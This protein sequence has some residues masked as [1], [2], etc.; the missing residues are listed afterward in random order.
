MTRAT[1]LIAGVSLL[2]L[3]SPAL[4]QQAPPPAAP[5]PTATLETVVVT[6]TKREENLQAVPVAVTALTAET[7]KTQRI[8]EFDDITRAVASLTLTED[9]ASPNNVIVLRGVGTFALSIG[10]EPSIAVI[11]DDVPVVQQAQAFDSLWDL[12]RIEVLEGPQGTLFGK[13][14]S[15][16]VINI[17]TKDPSSTPSASAQFTAT[18]DSDFKGEA[19]LSGPINDRVGFRISA[20]DD[21][22]DGNVRNLTDGHLLND[23]TNYGVRVKLKAEVTDKLTATFGASFGREDQQGAAYTLRYIDLDYVKPG[24]TTPVVP[25]VYGQSFLPDLVGI[26]PGPGNYKVYLDNDEP[27]TNQQVTVSGKLDY[28]FGF[29]DLLSITSY[30][31]WKYNFTADVDLSDRNT[32]GG[33]PAVTDPVGPADGVNNSGPY[34]STE[35]TQELRLVSK[36]PGPLSYV[37]GA[38]YADAPS[39]RYFQRGPTLVLADW[40]GYQDTRSFAGFASVDYKLPTKTTITG[41]FRVN[42]ERIQD[43]FVNYLPSATDY[44]SPTNVGTCGAGSAL[45]AGHN[46]DTAVTWKAAIDQELAP[47]V[48]AYFSAATGYKGYAYDIS[49]GYN[50]LRTEN[51]VLPEHST[52]FEVGIKSRFLDDRVQLNVTGFYADYNNFQAQ[53]AQY[54]DG[55]LQSK[56]N[57]VGKLRTRGF[58]GDLEA[59]A[60]EW[61][62][63][64]GSAAYTEA[65]I[66]SFPN[67]A[68]YAGQAADQL[69]EGI[70]AG[71]TG[72]GV[73]GYSTNPTGLGSVQDRSGAT[74]PNSPKLKFTMAAT[75]QHDLTTNIHGFGTLSYQHQSSVNFD[76]LGDPLL[77]Q[78][79]YGVFN[80]QAGASKGAFTVTLFANNLLNTHYASTMIDNFGTYG[81][82]SVFQQLPRDSQRYFGIK[83]S[84]SY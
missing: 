15:A 8:G 56:L 44:V 42:N 70:P 28:D 63:F 76:L 45:C 2:A 4:A 24:T 23:H 3:S 41:A 50:P 38:Y 83:I 66:I 10:V 1:L 75:V 11:V 18:T 43:Q 17:V 65:K 59:K 35:F 7:I 74:L 58:E 78:G 69:L 39:N 51:P 62:R 12:A 34:H 25:T 80:A 36:I 14:A 33:A 6:A 67:A 21:H 19:T 54:I 29:A 40:Y 9:R 26:T 72:L 60:N 52:S 27:D 71:P 84:A 37:V 13:N 61:L 31:D 53:S 47:E 49:S 64:D 77:T 32:N 46:D 20:Y 79:A 73:C 82:H 30:Q 5:A 16:G 55:V 68:C 22:Y 57:N 48:R 81:V